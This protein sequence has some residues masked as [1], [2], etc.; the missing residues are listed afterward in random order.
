MAQ[1]S[2]D[3]SMEFFRHCPECG[4]RF[5][6]K[7]VGKTMDRILEK[8]PV[9]APPRIWPRTSSFLGASI[10]I[11]VKEGETVVVNV[12]EFQYTYK[13]GHCGHEWSEKHVEKH[14]ETNN[15]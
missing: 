2:T 12:E 7:L 13:C 6:L 4:R 10:P 8:E 11:V 15:E 3:S 5:H 14:I 9:Y 1:V